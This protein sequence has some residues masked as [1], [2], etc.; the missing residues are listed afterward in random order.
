MEYI[1]KIKESESRFLELPFSGSIL[2]F[3]RLFNKNFPNS[4]FKF[5]PSKE[6]VKIEISKID[7]LNILGIQEAQ[8]LKEYQEIIRLRELLEEKY[9][10]ILSE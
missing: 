7:Y 10:K 5:S 8:L 6:V 4:N 3:N 9:L 1:N 2:I